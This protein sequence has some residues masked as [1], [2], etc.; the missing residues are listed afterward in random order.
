MSTKELLLI[1][2]SLF[3]F[4]KNSRKEIILPSV[5]HTGKL[6]FSCKA[7]VIILPSQKGYNNNYSIWSIGNK[8]D[9]HRYL[10]NLTSFGA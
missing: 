1:E 3:L 5:V 4:L 7:V 6:S 10:V 2:L 9:S 8:L